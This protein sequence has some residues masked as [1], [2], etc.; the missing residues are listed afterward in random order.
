MRSVCLCRRLTLRTNCG[1]ILFA[2]INDSNI[3]QCF[4]FAPLA[5]VHSALSLHTYCTTSFVQCHKNEMKIYWKRLPKQQGEGGVE[6]RSDGEEVYSGKIVAKCL[7]HVGSEVKTRYSVDALCKMIIIIIIFHFGGWRCAAACDIIYECAIK[8]WQW[9]GW[10]RSTLHP[11]ACTGH[12]SRT[13]IHGIFRMYV[14]ERL[15]RSVRVCAVD[16]ASV[17][18]E[19]LRKC[20]TSSFLQRI[21]G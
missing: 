8:C 11:I 9:N 1:F 17:R 21:R 3:L 18:V 2:A 4:I 6:C 19:V 14:S 15:V 5:E 16:L 13:K 12:R 7:M 10:T 20:E